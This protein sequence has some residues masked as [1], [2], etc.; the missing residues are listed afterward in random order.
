M[1]IYNEKKDQ[2][3]IGKD[4]N[5]K[6]TYVITGTTDYD[7]AESF[8]I[9]EIPAIDFGLILD[10]IDLKEVD[11]SRDGM[12]IATANYKQTTSP[13]RLSNEPVIQNIRR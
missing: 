1:E 10:K 11:D 3:S 6:S 8:A 13:T 12:W 9:A 5:A 2:A 7:T 4:K